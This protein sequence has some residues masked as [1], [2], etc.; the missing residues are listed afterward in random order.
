M[1]GRP[2][3]VINETKCPDCKVTTSKQLSDGTLF[4]SSCKCN[5]NLF[6]KDLSVDREVIKEILEYV[7]GTV[8]F[9]ENEYGSCRDFEEIL[10]DD[11]DEIPDFYF[12]LKE[13]LKDYPEGS[14]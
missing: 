13:L 7:E 14:K 4:R 9:I 10:N 5:D 8:L 3:E 6:F 2:I 12:K 11:K 1:N